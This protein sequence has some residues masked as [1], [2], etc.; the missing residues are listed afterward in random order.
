MTR[1]E[2]KRVS[3]ILPI[4]NRDKIDYV[5]LP[6]SD[7]VRDVTVTSVRVF[8]HFLRRFAHHPAHWNDSAKII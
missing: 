3:E 2:N 7:A 5:R 4:P 6:V 8:S 1:L